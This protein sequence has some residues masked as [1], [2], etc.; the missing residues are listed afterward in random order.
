LHWDYQARK[1]RHLDTYRKKKKYER[2][3]KRKT[4][5]N[6]K[7]NTLSKIFGCFTSTR[8]K[9]KENEAAFSSY[10]DEEFDSDDEIESICRNRSLL[11]V[12][13]WKKG[14]PP[15]IRKTLWPIV[16]GNRLE[17]GHYIRKFYMDCSIN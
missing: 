3:H 14:I 5:E 9:K 2:E 13:L 11:L 12:I 1:P 10:H 16:I 6:S 15:W 4:S 17:V 8:R 7:T